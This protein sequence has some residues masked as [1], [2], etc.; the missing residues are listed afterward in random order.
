MVAHSHHRGGTEPV[1]SP[2]CTDWQQLARSGCP[3]I[4]SQRHPS[5]SDAPKTRPQQPGHQRT[6]EPMR[7]KRLL[8]GGTA[9]AMAALVAGSMPALASSHREAPLISQDPVADNTDLYAFR[10]P[11]DP[12]K[13]T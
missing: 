1:R 11:K 9:V 10:D 4:L 3:P 7:R 8:A 12:N 2:T 6:G 5:T 13:L